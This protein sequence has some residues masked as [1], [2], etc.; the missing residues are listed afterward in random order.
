VPP[1]SDDTIV[2]SIRQKTRQMIKNV[3]A[4]S[5]II[6]S[7]NFTAELASAQA[8]AESDRGENL[9]NTAISVFSAV[10]WFC[11]TTCAECQIFLR[12]PLQECALIDF[13][14][15]AK[16]NTPLSGMD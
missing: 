11:A 13:W 14:L 8:W 5:K 15:N 9:K 3:M 6:F 2:L 16:L 10:K 7:K 12:T 1:K 4:F